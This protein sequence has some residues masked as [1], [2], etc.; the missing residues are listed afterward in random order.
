MSTCDRFIAYFDIMGF[1]DRVH[2]EPHEDVAKLLDCV[3][4]ELEKLSPTVIGDM[5]LDLT[6][7]LT[8]PHIIFSDTIVF[9]SPDTSQASLVR[10]IA[11]AA[12]VLFACL[13][14]GIPLKGAFSKGTFTA[15]VEKSEYLGRPL[16]DAYLLAEDIQFYGVVLHH[17]VEQDAETLQPL[18][19]SPTIPLRRG[20]VPMKNGDV[21]HYH[22]DW[23]EIMGWSF[24]EPSAA[25][26]NPLYHTVSGRSRKYVDNTIATYSGETPRNAPLHQH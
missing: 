6:Q 20:P 7:E 25:N 21:T 17:T 14:K 5:P 23:C 4:E 1:K 13:A 3:L 10:L 11:Q 22:V 9:Y 19:R 2:S 26:L 8:A 16:T 24:P 15:N 18:M 12:F